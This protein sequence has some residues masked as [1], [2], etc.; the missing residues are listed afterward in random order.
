MAKA[1]ILAVLLVALPALPQSADTYLPLFVI[2]RT[3][4]ANVVH[5]EAKVSGGRLDPKEPVIA[6]WI[7]AAEHGQREKL[8]FLELHEAYGFSTQKDDGA[9]DSYSIRIV[10][11]RQRAIHVSIKNGAAVGE[12]MIGGHRAYLQ[13]IFITTHKVLHVDKTLY[14][15]MFGV[16]VA[17]GEKC[18]EKILP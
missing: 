13:R 3:T 14:A 1:S 12:T 15:E 4:N 6:Y 7:M 10:S 17:T 9:G 5:Y 11:D 8:S 16:D 2:E 18:Y